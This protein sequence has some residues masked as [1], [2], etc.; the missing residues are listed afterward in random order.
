MLC[1][2]DPRTEAF[3][4][5]FFASCNGERERIM[6]AYEETYRIESHVEKDIR[7]TFKISVTFY[8]KHEKKPFYTLSAA[9]GK[10]GDG[11]VYT[12]YGLT[13]E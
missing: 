10:K 4:E 12:S 11:G 1:D 7:N 5:K 3:G 9:F 13:V 8:R 2:D 6:K